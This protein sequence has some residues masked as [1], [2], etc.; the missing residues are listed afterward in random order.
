[1][2][3][4]S[5]R[6]LV[7]TASGAGEAVVVVEGGAL[8][9]PSASPD[10]RYIVYERFHRGEEGEAADRDGTDRR[11]L[12]GGQESGEAAASRGGQRPASG[13]NW[14][15]HYVDSSALGDGD[16]APQPFMVSED[17]ELRPALSPDA[18]RIAFI[19]DAS[20]SSEAWVSTFPEPTE[21][22]RISVRGATYVRWSPAGDEIFFDDGEGVL[23]SVSVDAGAAHGRAAYGQPQLLFAEADLNTSF[24]Y[25]STRGWDVGPGGDRFLIVQRYLDDTSQVYVIE[26]FPRWYRERRP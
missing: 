19:S 11:S 6:L 17:S 23:W 22:V 7:Q 4:P 26:N 9:R 13:A 5:D 14:D 1:V 21:L 20:G 12:A 10:G 24:D 18:S 8:R 25:Y 16:A 2:T 3:T 15:I